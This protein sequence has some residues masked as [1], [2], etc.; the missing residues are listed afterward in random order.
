MTPENTITEQICHRKV[1]SSEGR[2][3][4]AGALHTQSPVPGG[5]GGMAATAVGVKPFQ[6]HDLGKSAS[7]PE[8][9]IETI[10]NISSQKENLNLFQQTEGPAV[11][12]SHVPPAPQA[13]TCWRRPQGLLRGLLTGREGLSA[14]NKHSP[15][16]EVQK[17]TTKKSHTLALKAC[18]PVL[19]PAGC[20]VP[21]SGRKVLE[22]PP[23]V[24]S[25]LAAGSQLLHKL[26]RF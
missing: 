25:L 22:A 21:C 16:V 12:A 3:Q 17:F 8:K 13:P 10:G 7:E 9:T 26:Q 20:P 11:A 24:S 1:S 5:A 19:P 14:P 18:R 6:T 4:G 23:V 15:D 2:P